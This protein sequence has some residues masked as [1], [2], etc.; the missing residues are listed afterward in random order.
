M[1]YPK[2]S[3]IVIAPIIML[4]FAGQVFA[5]PITGTV[6]DAYFG[7]DDHG[8][9][10]VVGSN[11]L[12]NILS[13]DYSLTGTLLEI[14]VNTNFANNGVGTFSNYTKADPNGDFLAGEG[15]TFGDLFLADEWTP[16][17]TA[18]NKYI[19]DDIST[20]TDWDYGFSLADRTS[21]TGGVGNWYDLTGV[22]NVSG[23]YTSDDY[24]KNA[25][26]RNGQEVSVNRSAVGSANIVQSG[27]NWVVNAGSPGTVTFN[28]DIAGTSLETSDTIAFHWAMSCGN[29]TIE[30][31]F[32]K[33]VPAPEPASLALFGLG[34]SG[35][36]LRA[37]SR[38]KSIAKS[39]I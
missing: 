28:F 38:R 35:L 22:D 25:I 9:G 26:W 39:A 5:A 7:G 19:T 1:K 27:V 6:T 37:R 20:G 16:S 18:A 33:P 10:D 17:G 36:L 23:I 4:G 30:G 31:M 34:L 15:I 24:M 29:D 11:S 32:N 8:Y 21:T 14:S 3:K 12:F 13:V 2:M